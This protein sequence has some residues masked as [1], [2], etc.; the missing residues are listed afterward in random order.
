MSLDFR[1][2]I[3]WAT[4]P[5][6]VAP[7][8]TDV[9]AYVE[10]GT[11]SIDITRG[12]GDLDS[13][14][15][16]STLSLTFVNKDGRFTPGYTSGAYYPNVVLGK[17]IQVHSFDGATYYPRFDGYIDT[18]PVQWAPSGRYAEATVT[19]VDRLKKLGRQIVVDDIIGRHIKAQTGAGGF[20]NCS[21][22][23]YWPMGDPADTTIPS[24][25][26]LPAPDPAA[27]VSGVLSRLTAAPVPTDAASAVEFGSATGPGTDGLTAVQT[28]DAGFTC[29]SRVYSLGHCMF[30]GFFRVVTLDPTNGPTL[31]DLTTQNPPEGATLT[32]APVTG[33]LT[34][35]VTSDS[36]ATSSISTSGSVADGQT[37][38]F[39]IR[40]DLGTSIQGELYLDG[41][42]VGNTA[43]VGVVST[44]LRGLLINTVA[45]TSTPGVSTT[46]NVLVMSHVAGFTD[47]NSQVTDF[48]TI[49]TA[50]LTGFAGETSAARFTRV[51]GFASVTPVVTGTSGTQ[52]MGALKGVAGR[53]VLDLMQEVQDTENGAMFTQTGGDVQLVPRTTFYNQAAALTLTTGQYGDDLTFLA[54]DSRLLNDVTVT[55]ANG[56][57]QEV[58]NATSITANGTYSLA[59]TLNTTNSNEALAWAQW[60][61]NAVSTTNAR[62]SQ[63]SL[64]LLAVSAQRTTAWAVDIGN[65]IDLTGLP[66]SAPA[67]S[68]SLQVAG[69]TESY[70]LTSYVMTF[71]TIPFLTGNLFTL[72]DAT[73]GKLDTGGVLAY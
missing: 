20:A 73:L 25:H 23:D 68:V 32:I 49:S 42:A 66:S 59:K 54:D 38:H 46:T 69:Y 62:V 24:N 33:I 13:S 70:S 39:A 48:A 16:P 50:G 19:A 45:R 15:N 64:D 1:V 40:L 71:N 29:V 61:V 11:A 36:T 2:R 5:F 22:V 35:T 53:S 7:T 6:S 18:L 56:T 52:T 12:S 67:S 14:V 60:Q 34:L 3:A 43:G 57:V 51:S 9:S 26:G 21:L 8:W 31:I 28:T 27:L 41:A 17:R 37:H 10:V 65:R 58:S 47:N 55:D 63:V 4:D 72:N 44:G 30:M